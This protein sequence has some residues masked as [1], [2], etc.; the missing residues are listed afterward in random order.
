M[1][2]YMQQQQ[3]MPQPFKYESICWI[4]FGVQ[5]QFNLKFDFSNPH[6][7]AYTLYKHA[8]AYYF[9]LYIYNIYTYNKVLNYSQLNKDNSNFLF[10]W[11]QHNFKT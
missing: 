11:T 1:Y 9:G 10:H 2:T 5:N 8:N 3:N 6:E 4:K 7:G